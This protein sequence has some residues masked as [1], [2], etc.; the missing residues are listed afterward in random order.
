MAGVRALG[1]NDLDISI[2]NGD[3]DVLKMVNKEY[4]AAYTTGQGLG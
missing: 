3:D 2:E 4:T 1:I